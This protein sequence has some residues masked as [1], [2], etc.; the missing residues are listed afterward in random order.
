MTLDS[1]NSSSGSHDDSSNSSSWL[2]AADLYGRRRSY[3]RMSSYARFLDLD[4]MS[5][6]QEEDDYNDNDV[7]MK[8]LLIEEADTD[9]HGIDTLSKLRRWWRWCK[10]PIVVVPAMMAL[11]LVLGVSLSLFDSNL[12]RNVPGFRFPLTYALVQKLTNAIASLILIY[13]SRKW[14]MDARRKFTTANRQIDEDGL[15]ELPSL[16]TF[17]HHASSL[18]AVAIVQTFSSAFANEALGLIPLPL[19]KVVLMC[20]PIFV[21]FITTIMEGQ[22]YSRG[23]RFA[24]LLIGFGAGRAVYAEAEKADNPR[25]ILQ[26]AGYGLGASAFSAV[27]L[28]LSSVLMHTDNEN[29]DAEESGEEERFLSKE[30]DNDNK[31]KAEI[32]LNPL[33]LLFYLSCQQVMMLSFYLTLDTLDSANTEQ[34]HVEEMSELAA[35]K[36][37]FAENASQTMFYLL[38]GSL[39]SLTLAVLTFALVNCT[40]PVATSLLGNVRS[41]S[42]VAISSLVFEG[43]TARSGETSDGLFN[44]AAA[45]YVLSLTGGVVYAV[46][47]LAKDNSNA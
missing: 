23:R 29:D 37:Y 42:T 1:I 34:S 38:L 22:I 3:R 16:K 45:G 20:G 24:L 12:L 39:L 6:I 26:G 14:E 10:S 13:M 47:A 25:Q 17:R 18:T 32:E 19:F 9:E 5:D 2:H 40:S 28:V 15:P 21:A 43:V 11:N 46:A 27:A 44:S 35:F 7:E 36:I 41:I 30:T 8:S 33:S 4:V 31:S